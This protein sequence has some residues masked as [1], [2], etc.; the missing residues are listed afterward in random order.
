MLV[1]GLHLG[2]QC[3]EV[4]E[5]EVLVDDAVRHQ[6]LED[7]LGGSQVHLL[8]LAQQVGHQVLLAQEE[9]EGFEVGPGGHDHGGVLIAEEAGQDEA[10]DGIEQR[11]LGA[12]ELDGVVGAT[13]GVVVAVALAVGGGLAACLAAGL[14][15]AVGLGLGL[16]VVFGVAR[17]GRRWEWRRWWGRRRRWSLGVCG[18]HDI[19]WFFFFFWIVQRERGKNGNGECCE[20]DRKSRWSN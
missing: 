14:A 11:P 7:C 15:A 20:G 19:Y 9:V 10:G 16:A 5:E 13:P 3:A 2:D 17:G 4:L 8:A 1:L 12:V 6:L 18:M